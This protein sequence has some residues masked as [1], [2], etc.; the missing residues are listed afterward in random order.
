MKNELIPLSVCEKQIMSILWE[1]Q[2][3][4]IDLYQVQTRAKERFGKV[5]K[6]QTIA[7]F[8]KRLENKKY[9]S[10]YRVGRY[11]HYHPEV[12]LVEYRSKEFEDLVKECTEQELQLLIKKIE[13][14]KKIKSPE[15]M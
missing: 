4:D 12:S 2:P 6:L 9:I 3:E 1:R 7:T 8:L 10:V 15:E 11:S 13:D 5:W 14:Y